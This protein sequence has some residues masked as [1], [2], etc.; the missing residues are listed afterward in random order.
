MYNYSGNAYLNF[1]VMFYVNLLLT[2][3]NYV[4]KGCVYL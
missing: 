4:N 1:V 2:T 3:N